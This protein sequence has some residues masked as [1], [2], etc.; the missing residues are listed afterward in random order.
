MSDPIENHPLVKELR[1]KGC[2]FSIG[3]APFA[4]PSAPAE[5]SPARENKP[6]LLPAAFCPPGTW[7]VPVYVY[8]GDNARGMRSKVGRSGHERRAVYR[9]LAG[10]HR[11][12]APF[13]D[14]AR[15]GTPLA[16]TLTRLGGRGMD[17]D[18]LAGA[19]KYVRDAVSD[20]LGVEDGPGG[21][22]VWDYGQQPNGPYGVRIQLV[23]DSGRDR[24]GLPALAR[25]RPEPTRNPHAHHPRAHR[26]GGPPDPDPAPV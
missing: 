2:V 9:V 3:P 21:P 25:A 1:A 23:V 24:A 15:S 16:C 14:A 5:Q 6:D 19:M 20:F 4:T 22:V 8:S 7:L 10:Y 11:E 26:G 17:S 18:G 13:A 12:F